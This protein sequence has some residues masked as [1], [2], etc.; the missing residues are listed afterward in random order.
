MSGGAHTTYNKGITSL[1]VPHDHVTLW[2]IWVTD[3]EEMLERLSWR[4]LN[5]SDVPAGHWAW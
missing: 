2:W 3:A 1:D 5:V 4:I